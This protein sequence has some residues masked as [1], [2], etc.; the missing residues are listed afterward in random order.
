MSEQFQ[1]YDLLW[2]DVISELFEEF[3]LF[4][5]PDLSEKI[6]FTKTPQF[7]EQELQKI[8]PESESSKRI[9]DKLVKL[10]LKGGKEQWVYVHIEVQGDYKKNFP[11]RMFQSFYRIFDRYEQEIYALALFT[12]DSSKYNKDEYH[13][14]FLGTNLTYQY[15]TYKIAT[16]SESALLQSQNPFALA[17]L[18]GLYLIKSK[19]NVNSKYGYKRKLMRLLLQ[20]KMINKEIKRVHVQKLLIFIDNII[21]LPDEDDKLFV[22]EFMPI[23]EQEGSNMGLSLEDTSFARYYRK[24]GFD[25]GKAIGKTEEAIIIAKNLL[26]LDIDIEKIS[27]AT[28][29]TEGEIINLKE[30]KEE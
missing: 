16:Q 27:K 30:N 9:A 7:L 4:F 3:L 11:K 18:A 15:N 12:D 2:K 19:K 26:N 13:Y 20:D 24:E 25:K 22:Q 14:D 1:K 8:Y 10:Q 17:V 21:M 5:S 23:I 28:G 29:L 6:D